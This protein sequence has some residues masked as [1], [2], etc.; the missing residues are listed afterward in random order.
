MNSDKQN[1]VSSPSSTG[2]AGIIFEQHVDAIFLAF[3]LVRA[4]PPVLTNCQVSEI[5]FQTKHKGWNTDDLLVVGTNGRGNTRN[6]ACQVKRKFTISK[7]N[8]ECKKVFADFWR[9]FSGGVFSKEFDALALVTLHGTNVLLQHFTPLLD[10]AR[11]SIDAQDFIKRL[12]TEGLLSISGRTHANT[13][14]AIIDVENGRPINDEEFWCFL[15]TVHLLSYDLTTNSAQTESL[16]KTLLRHSIASSNA[17]HIVNATW[18][19]L[20]HIASKGMHTAQSLTKESFPQDLQSKHSEHGKVEHSALQILAE[21]TSTVLNGIQDT[22]GDTVTIPRI[23]LVDKLLGNLEEH[24]VVV[25]CGAAGSGKSAIAKKTTQRL[26]KHHYCIAFRAEEFDTP[27]LDSTLHQGQL[28]I[29]AD[30]LWGV[31]AAQSRKFILIESVER[32]LEATTRDSFTDLL[33]RIHS[34][35]SWRVVLT[36]RDYSVNIV[37][38]SLLAHARLPHSLLTIPDFTDEEL[39]QVVEALP[40]LKQPASNIRLK[41]LLRRPY[42]LEMA[43]RMEWNRNSQLPNDERSFRKKF[44]SEIVREDCKTTA[45]LPQRRSTTFINIAMRRA[46]ALSRYTSCADLDSEAIIGL[47]QN[48]LIVHPIETNSLAAPA[49]DILEDWAVL[50]WIEEL[51]LQNEESHVHL[52]NEIGS[53]PALR[54]SY[55]KWLSEKLECMPE[56][57]D[58]FILRCLLDKS[59][60]SYFRDDTV[61]AMLMSNEAKPFLERH[62]DL[63]VKDSCELLLRVI[64]LLRVACMTYPAWIK[65]DKGLPSQLLVPQGA[66]W[67]PVLQLVVSVLDGL[68]PERALLIAGLI[69]DWARCVALWNPAPDGSKEAATIAFALLPHVDNYRCDHLR[70]KALSVITKIPKARSDNF[71]T[72]LERAC[73]QKQG[74]TLG[75]KF[76]EYLL[77]EMNSTF[78]CQIFPDE[79]IALAEATFCLTNEDIRGRSI[80]TLSTEIAPLFG[81]QDHLDQ[82]FF[83]PSALRGPFNPLLRFHPKKGI[84]FII[85][86]LNHAATWY[87]ETRLHKFSL[88][89]MFETT[90]DIPGYGKRTQLA[91]GRFWS[92]YRGTSVAPHILQTALMALESWLLGLA[93]TQDSNTEKLLLKCLV[94]SNNVALTAIVASVCNAYPTSTGSAGLAL[95]SCPDFFEMERSR[96][97]NELAARMSLRS[98]LGG[99]NSIY[100]NERKKAAELNHREHDLESLAVKLQLTDQQSAVFKLLD[101]YRSTLPKQEEQTDEQRLWKFALHRMDIRTFEPVSSPVDRDDLGEK[102]E[103]I[104]E[105]SKGTYFAPSEPDADIEVFLTSQRQ[106]MDQVMSDIELFNWGIETW[107]QNK[108]E[109]V[110]LWRQFLMNAQK[111]GEDPSPTRKYARSGPGFIACVCLR[112]YWD[113][114]SQT[115]QEWCVEQVIVEIA[116]TCDLYNLTNRVG[117]CSMDSSRPAAYVLPMIYQKLGDTVFDGRVKQAIAQSITHA[118]YEVVNYAA[119]GVADYLVIEQPDFAMTIVGA[120]AIKARKLTELIKRENI[121]PYQTR[122]QVSNL[123]SIL[124]PEIRISII[125]GDIDFESEVSALD[126]ETR[127]GRELSKVILTILSGCP[128]RDLAQ[129]AHLAIARTLVEWWELERNDRNQ[130]R[131]R[132]IEFEHY[133]LRKI[134]QFVLKLPVNRALK[135]CEPLISSVDYDNELSPFIHELII[136]EDGQVGY[137]P[138]WDIWQAFADGMTSTKWAS[139]LTTWRSDFSMPDFLRA[140][141]LHSYWKN[142]VD[143]WSRLEGHNKSIDALLVDLPACSV[144]LE[145]Y[146]RYLS[147]VGGRYLP[148]TFV[149]VAEKLSEGSA[150]EML[151]RSNTIYL[152]ESILRRFVYSEPFRLKSSRKLRNAVLIILDDLVEAG[153]SAAYQMRDDFVTPLPS[154]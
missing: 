92:I 62:R 21:H 28:E 101:G 53:F 51:F 9:D 130:R 25:V 34:D 91:N 118:A 30:R 120:L 76:A 96:L 66:G 140:M 38:S 111:R 35:H 20:L 136:T 82:S 133:T 72:L 151:A 7:T 116:S 87:S 125:K 86:L 4:V 109:D 45:G 85:K 108:K 40:K 126:L 114:L 32:L 106:A 80:C 145:A 77:D 119:R 14:R 100:D 67:A 24:R 5:H 81:L 146:L 61:V 36:C 95:L 29:T 18:L 75:Q 41:K 99:E 42:V 127:S 142:G 79:I 39:D 104:P 46:R 69:D 148:D 147:T 68:L 93:A 89:E 143:H 153:S 122:R 2:G 49:H 123:D 135:V 150:H 154:S 73:K 6:L 17:D 84:N 102:D 43:A 137:S 98:F 115:E 44:W 83:P 110:S 13:I 22:I 3:L 57:A 19:E 94:N 138:F 58:Q 11:A 55:R 144:A 74:D 117:K 103:D 141:F 131:E 65:G 71:I 23:G 107:S 112:D 59:L 54:R 33:Q 8:I 15:K 132:H 152:L 78:A 121:K 60:K 26:S 129:N 105:A 50:H 27:H 97:V 63:L 70:N 31:L 52:S 90:I 48:N 12:E 149:L 139:K 1:A 113:D 56:Y 134:A 16:V 88:E 124:D 128:E 37:R 64:H 10:M 47:R